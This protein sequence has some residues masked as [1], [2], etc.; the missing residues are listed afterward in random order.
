MPGGQELPVASPLPYELG[1]RTTLHQYKFKGR[2]RLAK[3]IGLLMADTAKVFP[4]SF[5]CVTY[6]PLH[7]K[8]RRARGYDQSELLARHL[9]KAL[10][11]PALDLLEK[12]RKTGTQHE[13]NA[14]QRAGNVQGAYRCH[15][16]IRLD[17]QSVLLIDDIVTT[18]STLREC[19]A[20]L[21]EAG[22]WSVCALCAANAS[23]GSSP[24][25]RT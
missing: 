1:F 20:A 22:A 19:A 4:N 11:L 6:V 18:G 5:H 10:G 25:S 3:P 15:S 24:R 23:L 14:A 21:Y 17:R 9:G 13:L 16:K 7:P 12:I 2:H 8:N